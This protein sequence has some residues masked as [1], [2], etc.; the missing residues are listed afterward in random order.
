MLCSCQPSSVA[1]AVAFA[2]PPH[3]FACCSHRKQAVGELPKEAKGGLELAVAAFNISKSAQVQ[4]RYWTRLNSKFD[5][6]MT[7]AFGVI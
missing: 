4:F 3:V 7:S 6:S 2:A 5:F 1:F